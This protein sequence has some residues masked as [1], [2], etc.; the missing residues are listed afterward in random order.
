MCIL[1]DVIAV[2]VYIKLVTGV[3][4]EAE[5]SAEGVWA[6]NTSFTQVQ[7]PASSQAKNHRVAW[8]HVPK[9]GQN[10]GNTL[11]H[12]VKPGIP[13]SAHMTGDEKGQN[14]FAFARQ[15]NKDVDFVKHFW[16]GMQWSQHTQIRHG[17]FK[18]W[19][20]KF[21]GMFRSP[22]SRIYSH[23]QEFDKRQMTETEAAEY[24]KKFRGTQARMLAGQR[25]GLSSNDGLGKVN[26]KRAKSRLKKFSFVG[27]TDEW[28][29]SICL[30]H[31]MFPDGPCHQWEFQNLHPGDYDKDANP[32]VRFH[33]KE[34]DQVYR[35]AK[36]IFHTNLKKHGVSEQSCEAKKKTCLA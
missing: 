25:Y 33:D 20:G 12:Y 29:L 35:L 16:K 31:K 36:K 3:Q 13:T 6:T 5:V 10:F 24:F 8:L 4:I 34:D 17:D 26:M 32:F 2:F 28:D 18:K 11:V 27:L 15:W 21:M 22:A 30:F 1:R 23:Q 19:K 9:C 7:S 14:A